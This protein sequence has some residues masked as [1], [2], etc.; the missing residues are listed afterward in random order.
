MSMPVHSALLTLSLTTAQLNDTDGI[1]TSAATSASPQNFAVGALNG[2]LISSGRLLP[3]PRSV[4]VTTT[5]SAAT[6][7]TT[8]PIV[9]TGTR[10]GR[11]VTE[12]LSLTQAGGNETVRGSQAF[13]T[14]TSIAIPA[15]SGTGGTF[16]FGVGDL[17]AQDGG[18]LCRSIK[19]LGT[20]YIRLRYA[21]DSAN[22]H[23]LPVQANAGEDVA[24]TRI[25][26]S[27]TPTNP[28]NVDVVL[29]V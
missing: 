23:S 9:I 8:D 17:C 4:T 5:T 26:A 19:P 16:Q 21:E 28:T 10:G 18:R 22:D 2:A 20:G 7:N 12:S 3:G 1:K 24:P 11:T 27:Q 25:I 29:Y 6:Y 15:Q 13:D 14:I